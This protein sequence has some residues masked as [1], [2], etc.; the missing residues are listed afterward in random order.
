MGVSPGTFCRLCNCLSHRAA[1]ICERCIMQHRIPRRFEDDYDGW[2]ALSPE[3]QNRLLRPLKW[4][5]QLS[6]RMEAKQ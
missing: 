5:P 2:C 1:E 4:E 3:E 6:S